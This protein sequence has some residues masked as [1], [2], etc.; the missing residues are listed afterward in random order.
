MSR[1]PRLQIAGGYY[2]VLA[3]AISEEPLYRDARD[4]RRF[5]ALLKPIVAELR[6]ELWAYC[7]MTTH[8]HLIAATPAPNLARGIQR[9]NGRYAQSFNRRWNRLGTSSPSVTRP[10]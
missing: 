1:A 10:T 9:L 2:H 7:V 3:R 5:V 4:R 6:W 8:Y